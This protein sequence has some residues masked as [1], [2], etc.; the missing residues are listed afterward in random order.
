MVCDDID[1][2]AG[3]AYYPDAGGV[4]YQCIAMN[5]EYVLGHTLTHEVGHF[6]GLIHT[7]GEDYGI[8]DPENDLVGDTP[9]E[10]RVSAD[11]PDWDCKQR[12]TCAA[13][14]ID[15]WCVHALH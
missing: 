8:C 14:G 15:P 6:F 11:V 2:G 13:A 10:T 1:G 3:Y 4:E 7:W 9:V 12:D 5:S